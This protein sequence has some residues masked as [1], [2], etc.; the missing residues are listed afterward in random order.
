MKTIGLLGILVIVGG[1]GGAGYAEYDRITTNDR[2]AQ[3]HVFQ[4]TRVFIQD[5]EK[6]EVATAEAVQKCT[7]ELY[8]VEFP[9]VLTSFLAKNA[10]IEY[11]IVRKHGSNARQ[12]R[13]EIED[14]RNALSAQFYDPIDEELDTLPP[15]ALKR[16][17]QVMRDYNGNR[18][19]ISRCIHK[20]AYEA[21]RAENALES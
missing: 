11:D 13:D 21:L 9:P 10:E 4:L 6:I 12:Q 2:T 20:N 14:M 16:T 5:R 18:K 17:L 7:R 3:E 1:V 19:P 15:Q 8:F